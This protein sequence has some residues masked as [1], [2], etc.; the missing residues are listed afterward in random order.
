MSDAEKWD[1]IDRR[2][3]PRLRKIITDLQERDRQSQEALAIVSQ[4]LFHL[5]EQMDRVRKAS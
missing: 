1:G 5:R 3:R 2:N 4:E